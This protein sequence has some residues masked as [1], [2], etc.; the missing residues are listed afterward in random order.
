MTTIRIPSELQAV[1]QLLFD[2]D[3][4]DIRAEDG[5]DALAIRRCRM[6]RVAHWFSYMVGHYPNW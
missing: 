1:Y 6:Y 2:S 5:S 4:R 3:R